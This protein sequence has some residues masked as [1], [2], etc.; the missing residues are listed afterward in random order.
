M[1]LSQQA[2][3]RVRPGLLGA[4][5]TA[6]AILSGTAPPARSQVNPILVENSLPGSPP[7]EWDVPSATGSGIEGYATDIS[8][9]HGASIHFKIKT[10]ATDYRLDIYRLG[11]YGGLGARHVT[12]V[13]PAVALPQAQPACLFIAETRTPDCGNWS[14]SATWN[15]PADAVSGIYIAKLV[16]E[17][18]EDGRAAHIVFVVRDDER[19]APLLFQ[20]SDTTWQAYNTYNGWSLY[21]PVRAYAVSYNRPFVLREKQPWDWVFNTEYPMLRWLERNGYDVSYMAGLDG[22]RSPGEMLEHQVFLSVGHDEYWSRAQREAVEAARDAGVHLCFFSGNEIYWKTRWLPS[23][24]GTATPYRTLVCYKETHNGAKID[25]LPDV[26]TGLWRDCSF[27]PPAD[28]CEPENQLSGQISWTAALCSGTACGIQVPAAYGGMR[29]WRHTDFEN[30]SPGQ[31]GTTAAGILAHEWDYRQYE[32]FDPPGLVWLSSTTVSTYTHHLS[33]Y[34]HP[35]GA[36]VFG[37]G[38]VQWAWGLDD[39]H[40]NSRYP[41]QAGLPPDSR[42]QQFTVNVLAEMGVQPGTLQGGLVAVTATGDITPPLSLITAPEPGDSLQSGTV[43]VQGV[44]GDNE[45]AV[46]A[47]E[48][49][50]DGGATWQ[51][52]EGLGSWSVAW[53]AP[54]HAGLVTLQSRATDDVGNVEVPGPGVQVFVGGPPLE[55]TAASATESLYVNGSET[56]RFTVQTQSNAAAAESLEVRLTLS[57]NLGSQYDVGS[58][59]FALAA[60]GRHTSEFQWAVPAADHPAEYT[61]TATLSRSG[62]PVQVITQRPAF[63]GMVLTHAAL[64]QARGLLLPPAGCLD[65]A[66]ACTEA[67]TGVIPEYGALE[68]FTANLP[69][70][71]AVESQLD[72]GRM[73]PAGFSGVAALLG[74][75]EVV[76][77]NLPRPESAGCAIPLALAAAIEC[78]ESLV[79][80]GMEGTPLD[81]GGR[82]DLL[83]GVVDTVFAATG[84]AGAAHV[85]VHGPVQLRLGAGGQWTTAQDVG[86]QDA[87]VFEIGHTG[88]QWGHVGPEPR[89]LG[90]ASENPNRTFDLELR[91]NAAGTVELGLLHRTSADSLVWVR[92]SPIT[93][94]GKTVLKSRLHAAVPY[95]W[96]FAL[97]VDIQGDGRPDDFRY[98][99][100]VVLSDAGQSRPPRFELLPAHPNPF[101]PATT[102]RYLLPAAGNVTVTLHDVRGRA[103]CTLERGRQASGSHVLRWDGR[104]DGG[105]R[106]PSG[107]YFLRVATPWG[108]ATQKLTIVR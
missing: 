26:W 102:I 70:L 72:A 40:T 42:M 8:V 104:L 15:V 20:T 35:S 57:T 41:P 78:H 19:H 66:S 37:A 76:L 25:P 67:S 58:D 29:L 62:A 6:A 106:P 22:E 11:Y 69:G 95:P 107:V 100:G 33:L 96:G 9:N 80:Q 108:T 71:C 1:T 31:V 44:A 103:L 61:L 81:A 47:V 48:I 60:R 3:A 74:A 49:S 63:T 90:S 34:K 92:Y 46:G 85:F 13:E 99:G 27:S 86:L 36:L 75:I 50:A 39:Q 17:D 23:L 18:P 32:R 2:T 105:R 73:V 65:E 59:A 12:T 16:R 101:N 52:A 21:T 51:R 94:T 77:A 7:S 14:V 91:S 87:F 55:I 64:A 56:A 68:A 79:D 97:A 54:P 45:G 38:A 4:L 10:D 24:D 84:P 82:L 30:L 28:G 53:S 83:A 98:P 93:V 89:P 5:L 88:I 43:T